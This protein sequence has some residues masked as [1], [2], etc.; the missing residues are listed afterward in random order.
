MA[1]GQTDGP[2]RAQPARFRKRLSAPSRTRNGTWNFPPSFG[3]YLRVTI[4]R[5]A[6]ANRC[7][8][9]Q[10]RSSCH[11]LI[12][13]AVLV[14]SACNRISFPDGGWDGGSATFTWRAGSVR[15]P[16]G[17]TYRPG[18]GGDSFEGRFTSPDRKLVVDHDIGAC[19]I[20][21]AYASR[22]KSLVFDERIVDGARVWTAT[23]EQ[24][25]PNGGHTFLFAVT[26]PDH[27]C[28]NFFYIPPS[29]KMP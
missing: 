29:P 23:K 24:E 12:S 20:S 1:F 25:L 22:E 15:L 2:D 4:S 5:S 21:G 27:E 17:F 19:Y 13:I 11:L 26:F 16:P 28:A 9:R 18:W 10:L 14:G 3:F 6:S 8:V 7:V